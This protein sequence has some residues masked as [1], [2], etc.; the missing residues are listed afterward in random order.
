MK[1]LHISDVHL[2]KSFS[3]KDIHTGQILKKKL[4]K[5]FMNAVDYCISEK[6][7]ALVIAGDLFDHY[8][9]DLS[10]RIFVLQAF[11]KLDEANIHV[12]YASGNHDPSSLNSPLREMNFPKN[13]HTFFE[14]TYETYSILDPKSGKSYR[15]IGCG[16]VQSHESRPLID[17]FPAGDYIGV[18]HTMVKGVDSD[19]EK[20]YL[21]SN[22]EVL[23][24]K[25]YL[26]FALGHVHNRSLLNNAQNIIY[27]GTLQ[28]LSSN[29]TG[30]RGGYLVEIFDQTTQVSFV[31]L[32]TINY[33]DF[34]FNVKEYDHL[35]MVFDGLIHAIEDLFEDEQGNDDIIN[36]NLLGPTLLYKDLKSPQ[37]MDT[38]RTVVQERFDFLDIKIN[39]LTKTI[40]NPEDFMHEKSVLGGV[41]KSL[42]SLKT[43]LDFD[44]SIIFL[45]TYSPED[46]K[47]LLK[48]MEDGL[49]D[50]FLEG[51]NDY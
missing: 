4:K 32:S 27:P 17:A 49:M 6:L 47:R 5:A 44:D 15:F 11:K 37:V 25:N 2:N 46:K 51:F 3:T 23:K 21:P 13:V 28:G 39:D 36:I 43:T 24:S 18:V 12:F 19:Q 33:K 29:E 16:H 9:L 45:N 40:Y 48:D 30:P 14:D 35:E 20:N 50:Y 34:N 7:N 1:F 31:E 22:L 42:E 41:L 26:Y 8:P 38:L 10:T